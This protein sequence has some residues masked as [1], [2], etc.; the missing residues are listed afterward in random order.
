VQQQC[1]RTRCLLVVDGLLLAG[2]PL[3]DRANAVPFG[4]RQVGL[5]TASLIGRKGVGERAGARLPDAALDAVLPRKCD[6]NRRGQVAAQFFVAQGWAGVMPIGSVKGVTITNQVTGAGGH[7]LRTTDLRCGR[8]LI[9][10]HQKD[11]HADAGGE[12]SSHSRASR[13]RRECK[14][15]PAPPG[16]HS[17]PRRVRAAGQYTQETRETLPTTCSA[18]CR[19]SSRSENDQLA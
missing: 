4:L 9:Q 12:Q 5:G 6:G 3:V 19:R 14:S 10:L 13:E 11:T 17:Y 18:D 7:G 1:L 15:Q 8:L 16:P 2:G